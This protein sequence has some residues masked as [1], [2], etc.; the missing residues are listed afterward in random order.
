MPPDTTLDEFFRTHLLGRREKVVPVLDANRYLG[1]MRIEELQT[2]PQDQWATEVVADHMRTDFPTIETGASLRDALAVMGDADIDLLP[3]VDRDS[4]V[5]VVTTTEILKLDDIL[6]QTR[7]LRASTA[8]A[9]RCSSMEEDAVVD[10]HG[11]G[12]D[13]E[14][15]RPIARHE[16]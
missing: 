10:L 14:L 11:R 8:F 3:V 6:D 2:V 15:S 13:A 4:F 1:L 5:G 9:G 12:H 7:I 16:A